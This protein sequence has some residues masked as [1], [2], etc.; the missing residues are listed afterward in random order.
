MDMP[1]GESK[2]LFSDF[3]RNFNDAFAFKD[4]VQ[5]DCTSDDMTVGLHKGR[6]GRNILLVWLEDTTVK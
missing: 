5:R 1:I 3:R 2:V 4:R 6:R